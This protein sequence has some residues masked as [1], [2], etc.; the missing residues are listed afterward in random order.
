[1]NKKSFTLTEL[2]I[3][4][5]IIAIL[6]LIGLPLLQAYRPSLRLSG[7]VRDLVTDLRHAQQLAVTEQINHGSVSSL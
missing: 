2:L 7:T 4:I 3:V 5:S 1:M 6:L